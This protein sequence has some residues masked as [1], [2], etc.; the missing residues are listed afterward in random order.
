MPMNSD[1][2]PDITPAAP[3]IHDESQWRRPTALDRL[4]KGQSKTVVSRWRAVTSGVHE[5]TADSGDSHHT[6]GIALRHMDV[7]FF[8][9]GRPIHDGRV[10]PGMLQASGP[11]EKLRA[12][13]RGA[14]D[15][16]H[17]HLSRVLVAECLEQAEGYPHPGD[18]GLADPRFS[19]DPVIERL[20]QSLLM[21]EDAGAVFGKLYA[22]SVSIAIVTRLLGLRAGAGL[23]SARRGVAALPKWRVKR[24]IEY[25]EAHLGG[26][27][28]LAE[29][30]GATGLTRMHFAA[31]FRIATGFRPHE[32]LLRKRIER[33]CDL[34][35]TSDASL[36]E[37][38][39]SVG[40]QTQAHFTTVFKRFVGATPHRWR[41]VQQMR[42][43][44]GSRP[45]I[46][47]AGNRSAAW[48]S[49]ELTA[50]V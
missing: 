26:P 43:A 39:L 36:V 47:E 35:L 8:L 3:F 2:A 33:A 9:A 12:V 34:L 28:T 25:V 38:A 44:P 46:P 13:F 17:I 42:L 48:P 41:S 7:A 16:L 15:V 6:I 24:A 21:A 4:A 31:Q 50:P 49:C 11:G 1:P 32:Y 27:I 19:Q 22:E 23:P 45:P 20:A 40:F 5:V 30:A 37:I 29:L 10:L 14:Y 18:I